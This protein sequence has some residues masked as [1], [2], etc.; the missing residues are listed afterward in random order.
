MKFV[1]A[2]VPGEKDIQPWLMERR[3]LQHAARCSYMLSKG[4]V[5]DDKLADYYHNLGF[6]CADQG[7]LVEAEQM[8]QRALQGKEKARGP[9]HTSTLDTVNNLA[10]L[11]A[12]Q[13]KLVEAEQMYQRALQGYEKAWGPDHTSTLS[14]VNNLAALYKNQ[15]KLVEAEQMYQRALQGYEKAISPDNITTYVLA[16][17]TIL[18]LGLLFERQADLAKARTLFSKALRGFKQ[19][20]GPDHAK[21]ETLRDHLYALDAGVENEA[22]IE[23]KECAD[24][25]QVGPSHLGIKK[26]P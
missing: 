14:T 1:G 7:K 26:P 8:Y 13:G 15:G 4:L 24:D 21:S 5:K 19:V 9:D 18:N 25:L 10:A 6:L 11:Y 16:L 23:I 3:L 17:N 2:H 12:D 20:F 22:S